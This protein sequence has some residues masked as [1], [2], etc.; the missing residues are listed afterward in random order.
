MRTRAPAE[1]D[2]ILR[3]L[4]VQVLVHRPRVSGWEHLPDE[5]PLLLVGNHTLG[6]VLDIPLLMRAM[7]KERQIFVNALGD[8]LH[9]KVPG[10]SQILTRY[11]VVEGSRENCAELFSQDACVLVFPGGAREV[12]KRK[13]E[14]R[15][16]VWGKRVGFARMAIRHGVTIVPFAAV[17]VEEALDIVVDADDYDKTPIGAWLDHL[18]VR[19]DFRLPIVKGIGLSPVPRPERFDFR[20]CAP[21]ETR[22]LDHDDSD[23]A[24]WAI[25]ERVAAGI[26]SGIAE[27][28][29]ER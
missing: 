4:D 29:S 18:G 15:Q 21:I 23:E 8:R 25:R 28:L 16:L 24:A 10:W 2:Q 12:A 17:G 9:F 7:W 11:G 22:S 5:R 26:E 1:Y 13:G 14:E 3:L 19:K 6:G 27:L 20:F